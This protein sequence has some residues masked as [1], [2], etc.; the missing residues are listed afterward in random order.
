MKTVLNAVLSLCFLA[1]AY[2]FSQDRTA[3]EALIKKEWEAH[4]QTLMPIGERVAKLMPAIDDPQLRQEMYRMIYAG[5]SVGYMGRF[6]GERDHPDFWPMLTMAH[7]FWAPNP[8]NVYYLAPIESDGVYRIT[9]FRGTVPIVD[10]Q[11][12]GGTI[13]PDGTGNLGPT[14]D[15]FDL[16]TLHI[17]ANGAFDFIMSR[18]RPAD[19]QGDWLQLREET[20]YLLVRQIALDWINDIDARFAIERLDTP[21]IKPRQSAAEIDEDLKS[22]ASWGELWANVGLA[23]VEKNRARGLRNAISVNSMSASGGT[24]KQLYIEGMFDLAPEEALILEF[25][26]PKECRYWNVQ[27]TDAMWLSIDYMNRQTHLNAH[28]ARVDSDG[29]FRAVI[30]A[31]DPGVPNWLDTAG[32]REGSITGRLRECS[33][34]PTPVLSKILLADVRK[35]IPAD[36]PVVTAAQRDEQIRLRKRGAQ[37]RRRW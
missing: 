28:L 6:L 11:T 22:V 21:A 26:V 9:G 25:D 33:S 4:V 15:N 3:D 17:G 23:W 5:M 10:M 13:I 8:D 19:Y 18:E 7:P 2:A 16:D 29:K 30:S 27:L 1:S 31:T 37:L 34:Y 35:H 20:T 32:Y 24:S 12:G 14:F 36:T